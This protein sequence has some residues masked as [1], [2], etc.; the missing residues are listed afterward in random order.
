MMPGTRELPSDS[1]SLVCGS[2]DEPMPGL[3]IGAALSRAAG[4]WPDQPGLVS[5]SQHMR[6]TWSELDRLASRVAAGLLSRGLQ[7][8]DRIGLW[9]MNCAEWVI[10]QFAVA[11][12]GMV[13]VTLN[14]AYRVPE[15]Q[16]ALAKVQCAAVFVGTAYKNSDFPE[17]LREAMADHAAPDACT[18]PRLAISFGDDQRTDFLA[19]ADLV[20]AAT[21][22][23]MG[24]LGDIA[25]AL[26]DNAP[27]NIQFTSGT[28]GAPKGVTLSHRNIM[29]NGWFTGSALGLVP[30]DRLCLPVPLYHCFGMVTGV[31][32]CVAHG[33]ALVLPGPGFDA[34]AV[35]EAVRTE[36]CTALYGVPTMYLALFAHPDFDENAMISLRTGIM[37]GS[38]CPEPLMRAA[39]ERLHMHDIAICYG[40]TEAP[41]SFQTSRT[42]PLGL[43]I[44]TVGRIQ[45]HI[46]AKIVDDTGE[47][48]ARDSVGE[49]L[50]RGY[51]TMLGYWGDEAATAAT[52][53]QDCWLRTGDLGVIDHAGY[54]RIVGRLKDMVIRGGENL[55][56]KEIEEFLLGHGGIVDVQVFGVRDDV[57]GEELCAW[58]VRRPGAV[59]NEQGVREFCHGRIAHH[60]VPRHIR[61]VEAF[62]LTITGKVQKSV[63]RARMEQELGLVA[64]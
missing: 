37:A 50:V 40:M 36:R 25:G 54:L 22:A 4:L 56:P 28:T 7:R 18:M 44:G 1:E 57:F 53:D 33:V 14:P 62:P 38:L 16:Q 13:L 24:R 15:L 17:M 39:I 10:V 8:G 32:A 46:A 19:W 11:R 5:P 60:K 42:D 29:N 61:F 3:S 63:L 41:V 58:I 49:I 51:N 52:R 30:G 48:V 27:A 2:T 64:D 47:T 23:D 9:S 20:C 55:Y 26:D 35:L 21:Q 34:A 12:A 43:R 31:L 6:F 45:P 59:L